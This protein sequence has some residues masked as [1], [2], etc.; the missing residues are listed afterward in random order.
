MKKDSSADKTTILSILF[1]NQKVAAMVDGG[2]TKEGKI[3]G[4]GLNA[5]VA[6]VTLKRFEKELNGLHRAP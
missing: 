1:N 6:A 3:K 4:K 5:D 2:L